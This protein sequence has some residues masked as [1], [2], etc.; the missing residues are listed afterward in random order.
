MCMF[1]KR[2]VVHLFRLTE[3]YIHITEK[4]CCNMILHDNKYRLFVIY[5]ID[6]VGFLKYGSQ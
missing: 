4:I 3:V 5:V 2:I 6:Y 1:F